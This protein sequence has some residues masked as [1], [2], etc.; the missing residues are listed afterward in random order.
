MKMRKKA[1][2]SILFLFVVLVALRLAQPVFAHGGEPRLEIN[3]E[4]I[5]PG[6]AIEVRGVEFEYDELVDLSLMG[7][8][9]PIPLTEVTADVEGTFTQVIV[10]P[11][12]L[13][14]G[15][16]ILRATNDHHW[17]IS[18]IFTVWGI[19]LESEDSNVN[20]DQSDVELGPVPTFAASVVPEA[21][22]Q[23]TAPPAIQEAPASNRNPAIF[24]IIALLVGILLVSAL[25]VARKR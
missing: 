11:S 10:L 8:T 12:D 21:V 9:I 23:S 2:K 24:L 16:Y 20:R 5:N 4:R 17:V 18:Q 15:E 19:A 14:A 1:L 3:V 25:T 7:T 13:P 6:G 22:S